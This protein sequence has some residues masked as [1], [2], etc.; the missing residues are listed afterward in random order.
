MVVIS[1]VRAEPP[2]RAAMAIARQAG[3]S[4]SRGA[5]QLRCGA[6]AVWGDRGAGGGGFAAGC[7]RFGGWGQSWGWKV[8]KKVVRMSV[9]SSH[10]RA[11]TVKVI[12]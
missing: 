6:V 9:L 5:A 11:G 10:F 2:V 7:R 12:L 8:P 1:T 4:R 3:R